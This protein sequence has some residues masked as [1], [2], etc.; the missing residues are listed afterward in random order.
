M[1]KVYTEKIYEKKMFLYTYLKC[2]K[3]LSYDYAKTKL[4]M[5]LTKNVLTVRSLE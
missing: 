2:Y 5:L 1:I 3:K 4:N